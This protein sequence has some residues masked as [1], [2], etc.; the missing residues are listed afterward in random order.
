M[1]NLLCIPSLWHGVHFREKFQLHWFLVSVFYAEGPSSPDAS[2]YCYGTLKD[3]WI[4]PVIEPIRKLVQVERQVLPADVM[5]C[6]D[7]AQLEQAPKRIKVVG[8]H[9]PMHI[10]ASGMT[11]LLVAIAE[12][13]KIVIAFP[14]I[15]GDQLYFVADGFTDEL[16]EC[17]HIGRFNDAANHVSLA[18]NRAD[19]S[20]LAAPASDMA[21][22]VPMAIL[23][24]TADVGFVYFHDAHKFLEVRVH[25]SSP[26]AMAHIPR[27]LMGRA[28]LPGDLE[29]TDA[30]LAIEHLPEH[31]KP[32]LEMNVCI[33]KDGTHGNGETIGRPLR[34]RARLAN[35]VPRARFELIDFGVFTTR[36]LNASG[37]AAL[38][39]ELF[40]SV[41]IRESFQELF[42]CHH[43][44]E[45]V[46]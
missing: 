4:L 43:N 15:C 12:S 45:N 39:Q 19:N 21:F 24:F 35:P 28:D 20:G 42:E 22:L 40:A 38:H 18:G 3:V 6:A 26:K 37:P 44:G 17:S 36:T 2:A 7:N 13:A 10:F 11:Y 25:H 9:V 46:A 31:F 14:F 41:V 16:I 27:G 33:L 29:R 32:R 5:V 23:V 1:Q 8:M 30:L 34:R